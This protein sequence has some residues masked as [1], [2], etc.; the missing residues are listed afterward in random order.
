MSD[1]ICAVHGLGGNAF[2]TWMATSKMWLR[3]LLPNSTPFG[4]SRIMIFGYDSTLFNR[5]SNDRIRDWAD[6]LLKQIGYVRVKEE[7]RTRPIIFICHSL[8]YSL[9]C[10]QC[11]ILNSLGRFG[12][13]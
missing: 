8:V 2:D 5:K 13:T 10:V 1:S 6:E 3:D 7:E 9:L 11:H 12:R 4:E